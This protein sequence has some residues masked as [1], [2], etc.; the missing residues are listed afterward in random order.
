MTKRVQ[1]VIFEKKKFQRGHEEVQTSQYS[2]KFELIMS[3]S[4]LGQGGKFSQMKM[5]EGSD[6]VRF[7]QVSL[8]SRRFLHVYAFKSLE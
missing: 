3:K 6:Y 1:H 5:G 2:V 8:L 4:W 7:S